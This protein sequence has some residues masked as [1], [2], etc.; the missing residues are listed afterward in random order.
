MKGDISP[1]YC[2]LPE[3]E[4]AK[5]A[6]SFPD[7]K[8]IILFRN[9]VDQLW[10]KAKMNILKDHD[11]RFEDISE[12]EFY[13]YFKR[14]HSAIPS[15][16]ALIDR[17]AKYFKPYNIHVNF[18]EKLDTEPYTFYSEICEFLDIDPAA[19]NQNNLLNLP[20]KVLEGMKIDIP[21]KYS[22]YISELF[23]KCI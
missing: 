19:I 4:I 7:I 18:F 2:E 3:E 11:R 14:T 21:K 22:W 10:S 20:V 12:E 6:A 8:I 1:F 13:R 23:S 17:W 16:T 15:Y 9:P 5:I